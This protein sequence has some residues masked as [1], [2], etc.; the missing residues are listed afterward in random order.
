MGFAKIKQNKD[1]F[2]PMDGYDR[3]NA[4][5]TVMQLYGLKTCDTCRK[6]LKSL[7]NAE[8]VDVRAQ[9]IPAQVL[10]SAF[11]RFSGSLLNV[12]L[13]FSSSGR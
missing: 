7:D 5:D 12:L 10:A 1:V 8:L 6:A 11:A 3:K 9:G 4:K 2:L 13:W